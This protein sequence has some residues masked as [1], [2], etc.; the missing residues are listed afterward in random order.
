MSSENQRPVVLIGRANPALLDS[1]SIAVREALP[2]L[3]LPLLSGAAALAYLEAG[4][5]C[6]ALV[7]GDDDGAEDSALTLRR[8][9][10]HASTPLIGLAS[11]ADELSFSTN[12]GYGGDE[13]VPK[14]HLHRLI[15]RI[16][17]LQNASTASLSM[18]QRG[19]AVVASDDPRRR[20]VL[21][22]TLH[23][24]GYAI[25]FAGDAAEA[26]ESAQKNNAK[27]AVLDGTDDPAAALAKIKRA[28]LAGLPSHWVLVVEPKRV[29]HLAPLI[30]G[31][32][33]VALADA[34]APPENVLFVANELARGGGTEGR[35][36]ARL[37]FGS[38]VHFRLAGRAED[39]VGI[40][41][42]VSETGMYVRTL[43]APPAK[44]TVWL[45]LQ[46]P[47]SD[48]RVRLEGVVQWRRPYGPN[49]QA[50]VPMG[51]GFEI[52]DGSAT[53]RQ[54]FLDGYRALRASSLVP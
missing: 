6:I 37:L 29:P 23:T 48:R 31:L 14:S 45:E 4:E 19:V 28:R 5:P 54:R 33:Y 27:L 51:F 20:I 50:T 7:D 36:S 52:S 41:Y 40:T 24:A 22:R 47:R 46:P 18:R 49:D 10:E 2:H 16:R 21:G 44:E 53:D 38:T 1:V 42:N 34:F 43:L 8:K 39:E 26:V 11:S 15:P 32:P 25:E 9:P 35:G 3:A 30:E 12:Y 13:V 17:S